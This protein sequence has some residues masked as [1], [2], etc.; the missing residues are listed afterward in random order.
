[1]SE[2]ASTADNGWDPG[3]DGWIERSFE[4]SGEVKLR[5]ENTAGLVEIETHDAPTTEVRVAPLSRAAAELASRA[6]ISERAFGRGHEVVV[7]IP[8]GRKKARDWLSNALSVGVR[9][10][11]P[12]GTQLDVFTVSAPLSARG[13]YAVASLRTISGAIAVEEITGQARIR[14]TSGSLE[15]GTV[16]DV[17]DVQSASGDVT[18]DVA[19]AGGR[20]S[21]ASGD[22]ALGRVEKPVRV[23]TASGDVSLVEAFQGADIETVSGDQRIGRADA[24][25]YVLRAVSGDIVVAVA[26][27][28]LVHIDAG[29]I[30]GRVASDIDLEPG[31][32]AAEVAA[33]DV[34]E[35]SI[36]AKTVSGDVSVIRAAG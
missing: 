19:A 17:V 4:T 25:D 13:S 12:A 6:R 11:V 28:T 10:R 35:I 3:P 31:R 8:R 1:M 14:T 15:V 29:S 32:P 30:S 36:Q 23:H 27:G 24:G 26:P 21:T 22:V 9:V 33:G 2:F 16:G 7:E 5:V 34:R 18:I 20:V